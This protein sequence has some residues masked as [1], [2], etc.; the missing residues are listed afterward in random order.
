MKRVVITGIGA[1]TA[2]GKTWQD[3][4]TA[5]QRKQNA[6]QAKADWAERYPELEARLGAEIHDYQP[7]SHWNRKQLRS[8]GRV[9]QFAVE[10]AERALASADLLDENG[11]ILAY[12]KDGRMGVACGSSTGS[13]NDIKD[14]AELLMTGKSDG[15]NANTYVRMMPHTTAANIGIFFGLTGRIIPTSSA[16]SSGS[17]GI[18]Y[19]YESIKYGLIPMMLAGGAEEFCPSEV[20]VFDSLYAASRNVNNPSKTPR[21][22]DNDRDGLVIGEGAGIFVLEE[23][24][25]AL[26][27]GANIIAEVVGYGANSDGAHVTRPQKDTMQCCMELALKDANLSTQKIGY[28]NG[29]GTAT[30]QGDIAETLATEAVFGKVPLSSQK[31][32]LG[33][34]LG[35]CGALESWFSI[36]M[37]R[38][39]WFAPTINLDNIDA[40]CGKLDYIQGD[41]RH[42]ETDYVMNNN[43]AFGGVNTSLIFKRWQV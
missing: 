12:L 8:L 36:E 16:C 30:E 25:H 18:G 10:A 5:F 4:K 1:V 38:D 37:M 15:F 14:A 2:F 3:I 24:R 35:A 42:I 13:T 29:H 26:A 28:V 33:H 31:S 19:A 32:Y 34:T 39:A 11:D 41:G 40:R 20:Y 22:Y 17:Q 27:R 23:L 9:S 6:V 43:F 7:P 21:P